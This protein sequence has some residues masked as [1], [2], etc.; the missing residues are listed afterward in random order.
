[1]TNKYEDSDTRLE[2]AYRRLGTSNPICVGCG[3]CGSPYALELAH[4]A[5][6]EFHDGVAILCSNCHRAQSDSEKDYP[7]QPQSDNPQM[8]T[9]GRY[10]LGLSEFFQMIATRMAEF[11]HWLL[12]QSEHVLPYTP[13]EV[14]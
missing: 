11:G 10:L 6:R 13:E 14:A 7:Y 5:P 3:F 12:E 1:M 8:E 2:K 9:I 4:I